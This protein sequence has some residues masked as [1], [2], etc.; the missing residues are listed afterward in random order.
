[1]FDVRASDG[2]VA[3]ATHGNGVYTAHIVKKGDILN[4][5]TVD[6]NANLVAH[7][8]PNPAQKTVKIV[9]NWSVQGKNVTQND[10]LVM[11]SIAL[12]DPLG[13]V[14]KEQ[15]LEA[16]NLLPNK[17]FEV[18]MSVENVPAGCYYLRVKVG[19]ALKTL[20]LFVTSIR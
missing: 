16:V 7:A 8:Y 11:S 9:G 1:M 10:L 17:G 12:I 6:K 13:R 2:T 3:L 15:P 18:V 14:V 5:E 20:P 4:A 19:K